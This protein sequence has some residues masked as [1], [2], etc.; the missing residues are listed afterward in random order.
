[1]LQAKLKMYL[2]Y[3]Q[4]ILITNWLVVYGPKYNNNILHVVVWKLDLCFDFLL[5]LHCRNCVAVGLD[6]DVL[7]TRHTHPDVRLGFIDL[8]LQGQLVLRGHEPLLP[9]R[10]LHMI[11]LL[12]Q[13]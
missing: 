2:L 7:C 4:F 6:K 9:Q 3:C 10:A 1:M 11:H 5:R 13:T 8:S 12:F